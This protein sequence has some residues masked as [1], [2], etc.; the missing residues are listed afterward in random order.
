MRRRVRSS[1]RSY[2]YHS[3]GDGKTRC[4]LRR[5]NHPREAPLF[6]R[7]PPLKVR[8]FGTHKARDPGCRPGKFQSLRGPD[9]PPR[10]PRSRGPQLVGRSSAHGGRTCRRR[11]NQI[12][13]FYP[14]AQRNL[15]AFLV[16][17]NSRDLGAAFK[18][19]P[20]I[21]GHVS[22]PDDVLHKP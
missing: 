17:G 6:P 18:T 21:A 13:F 5:R 12:V 14:P 3:P 9:R 16:L 11:L 19:L 8:A 1:M 2:V 15:C 20:R 22:S 10:P 4:I 7:C